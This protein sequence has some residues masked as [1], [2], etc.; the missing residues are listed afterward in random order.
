LEGPREEL[1]IALS[2]VHTSAQQG[3]SYYYF[4][5]TGEDM[6]ANLWV[7][8]IHPSVSLRALI[9]LS[10]PIAFRHLS[11]LKQQTFLHP[12][13]LCNSH[14]SLHLHSLTALEVVLALLS[15]SP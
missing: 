1:F 6:A 7:V 10:L 8:I 14:L 3:R 9:V 12:I 13:S 15:S 5:F 11:H 4:H 2:E